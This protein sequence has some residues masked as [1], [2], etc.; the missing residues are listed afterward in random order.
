MEEEGVREM[1]STIKLLAVSSI[2]GV[3]V[4]GAVV[5]PAFAWHPEGKI[6]KYVQ[7]QTAGGQMADAND[8]AT[9]VKAK[10][11]DTLKYIIII[12]NVGKPDAKG[13]NDMAKT[14]MTDT[15][16][17]GI[18]LVS[19][20]AQRTITENIGLL[21]PGE[22]SVKEYAVK[23]TSAKDADL[24]EN[25]ACFTGDST[26]ND[27]PQKGCDVANVTISNPPKVEEPPKEQPK[28]EVQ[29]ATT[30][31]ATGA[32]SLLIPAGIATG[33][34][35]AANLLRLKLRANKR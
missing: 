25:K 17:A 27:S 18:E 23:V 30:L 16:P 24:I 35:Y 3:V 1:K 6:K 11:G 20:P 26:V 7:N 29:A 13:Y 22:K 10:P 32:S 8:A 4:A 9:A 34:G 33:F 31:P 28:A 5:S 14:V 21:K 2:T 12:E 15:L 19:N